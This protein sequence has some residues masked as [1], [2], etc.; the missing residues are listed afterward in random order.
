MASTYICF[1]KVFHNSF[2]HNQFINVKLYFLS[3]QEVSVAF[4]A[5]ILLNVGGHQYQTRLSTLRKYNSSM[6]AAMFS[7]RHKLDKDEEGRYFL[8][9]NGKYFGYVLD[10]LRHDTVPDDD[11]ALPVYREACYYNLHTLI[12]AL[13]TKPSVA[14][15]LVKE[16]QHSL[17]PNFLELK[18]QVVRIAVANVNA[19]RQS[20]VTI[21]AFR[22]PFIPKAAYF[23]LKH[24]CI[25]DVADIYVGPWDSDADEEALIK[26]LENDLLEEGFKIKQH[27]QRKRCKYYNGQNCQKTI[28]K[29]VF[30]FQ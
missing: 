7:G 17:F 22:K 1:I 11:V 19:D 8:D 4:P 27:E 21:H 9:S 6:L 30:F 5:V 13:Q 10:Y 14:H 18:Q 2:L 16:S 29:I 12:D 28:Y 23:D 15:L 24:D 26:C 20:E 3:L 25:I